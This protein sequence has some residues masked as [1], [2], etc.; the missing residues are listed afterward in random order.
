MKKVS[1]LIALS[2]IIFLLVGCK[3]SIAPAVPACDSIS[4][5]TAT[6][7]NDAIKFTINATG[8]PL[9]YEC[10]YINSGISFA[11]ITIPVDRL[12]YLPDLMIKRAGIY[13]F[14]VRAV[15]ATGNGE[16]SSPIAVN[17][18]NYCARPTSISY[19]ELSNRGLDWSSDYT[20][21]QCQVQ[22]GVQGFAIGSGVIKT[23]NAPPFREAV[24]NANTTYDFY[25]RLGC[26]TGWSSWTGPYSYF[27]P[28]PRNRCT[29]PSNATYSVRYSSS[30][31]V[32]ASFTWSFNGENKCEFTFVPSRSAPSTGTIYTELLGGASTIICKSGVCRWQSYCLVRSYSL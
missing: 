22:Y 9:Y 8:T 7:E 29:P 30:T 24:M 5:F 16:W 15:C 31:P 18:T 10:Y 17:I 23:L 19:S 20:P 4:S 32:G 2:S 11:P 21:T 25:V 12:F 27:S 28:T 6:Q 14:Y 13:T 26:G 1:L 3:G